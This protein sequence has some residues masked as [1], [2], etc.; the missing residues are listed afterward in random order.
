M[1]TDFRP[2]AKKLLDAARA[3]GHDQSQALGLFLDYLLDV[4]DVE[5]FERH[6]GDIGAIFKDAHDRDANLCSLM[7]DWMN[8]VT[9]SMCDH[10]TIDFFGSMYEEMFQGRGKASALGQ[11][12]TPENLCRTMARLVVTNQEH[13]STFN[14]CACGSGRTM[15]AAFEQTD[16]HLANWFEGADIDSVSCKMCA[17]NFMIHGM[18]GIVKQQDTLLLTTPAVIYHINEVRY[19]IPMNYY[20]IRRVYPK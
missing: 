16:W 17:L 9:R 15:L 19:P 6:H 2:Y 18:L 11:F 12:F 14:D 7:L 1:Q 5:N 13:R 4:F 10:R 20:S 3:S 8:E